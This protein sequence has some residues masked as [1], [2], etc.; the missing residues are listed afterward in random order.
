MSGE[1]M[2]YD[3]TRITYLDGPEA[4]RRRPGMWVG[5]V[6]ERGLH[7]LVF[8]AVDE[9]VNRILAIGGGSVDVTLTRDGGVQVWDDG[10]PTPFRAAEGSGNTGGD[11]GPGAEGPGL[12]ERL[13][14]FHA[15]RGPDDRRTVFVGDFGVGLFVVNALSSR[16]TA[17]TRDAGVR[18]VQEYA[19]GV[20]VAAPSTTEPATGTGTALAFWP[21]RGIFETTRCSFAVLAERLRQVAFLNPGLGISLTDE[22]TAG[23]ARSV[24]FRFPDGVRDFVAALD[25]ESGPLV[26]SDV[27]GFARDDPRM[28]GSMQVA[29]LWRGFGAERV[30]GFVNSLATP[31]GGT[32]LDG[33]RDGVTDAVAA[34]AGERGQLTTADSDPG[35]GLI[36]AGLTAV[37]SVCLDRPE[38]LGATRGRLGNTAVRNCVREAVR[39]CL[40]EAFDERPELATEVVERVVRR[41]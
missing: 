41:V 4:V 1:D 15:G 18:R 33:F 38:I 24:R 6:G 32:H 40:R 29:L 26:S 20:A 28:A 11:E 34:I 5:S 27:I 3:A 31:E 8:G 22:R 30:L 12:D 14:S 21:D 37:V 39:E 25:A 36:G 23:A 16:L 10:T 9:A 2:A 35:A 19:Y 7:Q 13:T 17:E